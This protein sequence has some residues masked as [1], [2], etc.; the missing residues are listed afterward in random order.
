MEGVPRSS[1]F[2]R[3]RFD[4]ALV[5]V[6][7]VLAS[8]TGCNA[9]QGERPDPQVMVLTLVDGTVTFMWCGDD[10]EFDTFWIQ[11]RHGGESSALV[12]N[13][14]GKYQLRRG[15]TFTAESPP[16]GPDY[17]NREPIPVQDASSIYVGTLSNDGSGSSYRSAFNGV[18]LRSLP[19][20]TWVTGDGELTEDPCP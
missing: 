17:S 6:L 9:L 18:D 20:G 12:T 11:S 8:G 1:G 16:E 19:D 2:H 14:A 15:Q 5:L 13:G 4:A 10:A 7:V 3:R